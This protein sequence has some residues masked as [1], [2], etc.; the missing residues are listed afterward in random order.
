LFGAISWRY[1]E[2]AGDDALKK[3]LAAYR[4]SDPPFVLSDAFPDGWLPTPTLAQ[5]ANGL[6]GKSKPPSLIPESEFDGWRR[7]PHVLAVPKEVPDTGRRARRLHVS[8]SR[9]TGTPLDPGG[10]F[11]LDAEFTPYLFSIFVRTS[12]ETIA[13]IV[14]CLRLQGLRGFGK[15]SSTGF[16][17]FSVDNVE[18]CALLDPF[19]GANGFIA[20]SHFTPGTG[21]PT[22]GVWNIRVKYPKFQGGLV[23]HAFKGRVVMLTPGSVFRTESPVRE[24]YGRHIPIE[25]EQFRALH[26][27]FCFPAP[28]RLPDAG[29]RSSP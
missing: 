29:G 25:R 19:D 27:G 2:L 26:Y 23:D 16:G 10:L 7:E 3:W 17:A 18:E 8:V 28:A 12:A 14:E 11:E 5:F 9:Y 6:Q 15:R 1:C 22:D 4:D 21:D 20:L 13:S 24:W